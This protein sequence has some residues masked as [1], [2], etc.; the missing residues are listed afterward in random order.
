VPWGSA[1]SLAGT[2]R[3]LPDADA[4]T[5]LAVFRRWRDESG[6]VLNAAAA[7]IDILRPSCPM[8]IVA[9]E[10][11][12]DIAPAVS[13]ALAHQLGADFHLLPLASHVG[14]LLGRTAA[15]IAQYVADWSECRF[16]EYNTS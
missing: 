10:S 9:S 11:D 12:G 15:S 1:R 5:C 16:S 3:S 13:H 14:P 7:G 8:L 4:A 2:R 6:A